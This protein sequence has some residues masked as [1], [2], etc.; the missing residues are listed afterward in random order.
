MSWILSAVLAFAAVRHAGAQT[1]ADRGV[2]GVDVY[3]SSILTV[4]EARR[5]FGEGLDRYVAL[6]GRGRPAADAAAE[7]LRVALERQ[8]G[9]LLGVARAE[10]T[11]SEHYASAGRSWYALFDVVD[12]ADAAA[13][14]DFAPAPRERRPDPDGLLARWRR[15]AAQGEE[16]SRRGARAS[17]RPACPGYFC[18]WGGTPEAAADHRAFVAGAARRAGALRRALA[19]ADGGR[20][21]AALFVL[22]YSSSGPVVVALCRDAL[23]DPDARV[24]GAALQILADVA[25]V[26]PELPLPLGRVLARLDDP[27]GTVRAR[28][29]GLLV[30]L[31]DRDAYRRRMF[32]AAPR[33]AFL[34]RLRQPEGGDLAF[35]LLRVLSRQGYARSDYAVWDAWAARAA[36]DNP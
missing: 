15:H 22:S 25:N 31:A 29:M 3:R 5:R 35:T 19:D 14:L 28:A 26:H 17:E 4:E 36:S 2:S 8:A 11:I 7:A 23:S 9:S 12:R 16:L 10:L 34:L 6:R 18:L 20:R 33:L 1:A 13:R 30:P 32:S 24:R 27:S 21:A